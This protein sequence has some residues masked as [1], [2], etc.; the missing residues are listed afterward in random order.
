MIQ[1]LESPRDVEHSQFY[2]LCYLLPFGLGSA[3]GQQKKL[4]HSRTPSQIIS[5]GRGGGMNIKAQIFSRKIKYIC[6]MGSCLSE[7]AFSSKSSKHF[8]SQTVR[9]KE[10]TFCEKLHLPPLVMCHM[11]VSHV[12]WHV[13]QV[14][15]NKS[16]VTCFF[17]VKMFDNFARTCI[18]VSVH[19]RSSDWR[20]FYQQGLPRQVYSC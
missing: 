14:M 4:K 18:C 15:C 16:R 20:I 12:P 13:S 3:V 7:S 5:Q 17:F 11:Y 10:K 9:A 1:D 6:W 2:V 19:Y 8:H